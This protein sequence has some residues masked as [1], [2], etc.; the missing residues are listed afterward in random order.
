MAETKNESFFIL[1]GGIAIDLENK[2]KL[3]GNIREREALIDN[4]RKLFT[5]VFLSD[6]FIRN[7]TRQPES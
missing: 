6:K 1:L 3:S 5:A 2:I 7:S 4:W